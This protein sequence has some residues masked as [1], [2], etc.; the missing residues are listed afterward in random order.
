MPRSGR[1][2]PRRA[3]HGAWVDDDDAWAATSDDDEF[4]ARIATEPVA[5]SAPSP[6]A[7]PAWTLVTSE[8]PATEQ[9]SRPTRKTSGA[10]TATPSTAAAAAAADND[11]QT[12]T[13]AERHMPLG[14][15]KCLF[16]VVGCCCCRR[17]RRRRSTRARRLPRRVRVLLG[18]RRLRR[19]ERPGRRR[20]RTRRGERD[21]LGGYARNKLVVVRGR[22]PRIV[23]VDP[24]TMRRT[25]RRATSA[26]R[27][28]VERD[29]GLVSDHVEEAMGYLGFSA[30][31]GTRSRRP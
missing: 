30:G 24:R 29:V 13:W 5:L 11:E 14:P 19:H 10:S 23:V 4:V 25:P 26:A 27:H 17:R 12:F 3:A 9:Y 21:G 20:R 16:V 2:P 15:G 6:P 18:G 31:G 7:P 28:D 22:R 1:G 8:P